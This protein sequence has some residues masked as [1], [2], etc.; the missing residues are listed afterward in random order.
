MGP[1]T[2]HQIRL[3]PFATPLV[4]QT[5]ADKLFYSFAV[6][7]K[8]LS[9]ACTIT[10]QNTVTSAVIAVDRRPTYGSDTGRVE[11]KT[12]TMPVAAVVGKVVYSTPVNQ[13]FQPGEQLVVELLTASTAGAAH[14]DLWVEPAWEQPL[15]LANG[16]QSV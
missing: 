11:V 1:D 6:P 4:L 14:V 8:L 12:V 5:P 13:I 10:T 15:N 7:T 16:V 2:Q 3:T 9:I